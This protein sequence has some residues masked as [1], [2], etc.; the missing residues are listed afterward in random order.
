M[1]KTIE[2]RLKDIEQQIAF[3]QH[4]GTDSQKVAFNNVFQKKMYVAH[5]I[6][7]GSIAA[8]YGVFFI[9]PFPCTI[10]MFLESHE[11][12]GTN[13][14][15]VTLQLEKLTGTQAPDS[16]VTILV[17]GNPSINGV[18]L[19]GAANTVVYY[20]ESKVQTGATYG[21]SFTQVSTNNIRDY[22]LQKG[23]RL[24]LKDIGTMTDVAG[25]SILL[26]LTY[27]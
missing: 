14:G 21:N 7:D 24:A 15:A 19:K 20:P 23:D 22:V 3:H 27:N 5:S 2:Q 6:A 16:G 8:N 11:V 10:T 4:T 1:P 9:A 26:E 12:S 25:V 13:A 17:N 18:N